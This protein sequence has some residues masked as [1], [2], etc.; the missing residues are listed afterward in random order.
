GILG[1]LLAIPAY[2]VLRVFAKEFFNNIRVVQ[3][4]TQKI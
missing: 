1:M 3:K 4:L 2:T